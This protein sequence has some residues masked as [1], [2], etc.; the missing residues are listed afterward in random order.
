MKEDRYLLH[1]E[2]IKEYCNCGNL[3]KHEHDFSG[4]KYYDDFSEF[5]VFKILVC[6]DCESVTVVLYTATELDSQDDQTAQQKLDKW[7]CRSYTRRILYAP[8]KNL[9][10]SVPYSIA[11]IVNQAQSVF[12]ASP[13][14]SFILCRAVLEEICNDFDIDKEKPT[15]NGKSSYLGLKERLFQ[16]FEK[17][18]LSDDLKSMINCIKELGDQGAHSKH[19][20]FSAQIGTQD[21]EQ[22]LL[23]V[24]Y[25]IE[26][27]YVT[28]HKQQEA[29]RILDQLN[30]KT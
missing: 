24:E 6:P 9:H 19:L 2:G 5:E 25:V 23:L 17:E 11:D 22:L 21:A 7:L 1:H 13:R 29:K 14:A 16:L 20:V 27:L 18:D 15:N 30:G 4:E 8:T 3:L 12:P 26:N 28:K 10:S